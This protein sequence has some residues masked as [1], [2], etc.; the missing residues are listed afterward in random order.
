MCV[1]I[2][3][4]DLMNFGK[5]V[6]IQR[7]RTTNCFAGNLNKDGAYAAC[8]NETCNEDKHHSACQ[9]NGK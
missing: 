8:K 3:E 9:T 4:S 2:S 6:D 7:Y 5:K 1:Y